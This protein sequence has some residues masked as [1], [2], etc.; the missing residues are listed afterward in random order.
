MTA[1]PEWLIEKEITLSD[2]TTALW[3]YDTEGDMLEIFFNQGAAT[4]TVELADGVLL[5]LDLEQ[6][7]PLSLAFLSF[8]PLTR[9]REF[10]PLLRLNGLDDLPDDIRQTVVQ[11]ITS[12]PVNA[13][14]KVFSY[15]PTLEAD[16]VEPLA[17]LEQPVA[18]PI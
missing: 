5:R 14:L 18:M 12:P 10:P 15:A 9:R 7:R 17:L 16:R 8:T 1:Q 6:T 13:I 11:I 3:S 2:G 4:C